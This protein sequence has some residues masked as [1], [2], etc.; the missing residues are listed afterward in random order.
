[1]NY[2]NQFRKMSNKEMREKR[3]KRLQLQNE[4][5]FGQVHVKYAEYSRIY[6]PKS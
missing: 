2:V 5:T 4:L 6:H 1:M 3:H